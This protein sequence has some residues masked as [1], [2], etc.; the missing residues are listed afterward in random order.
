MKGTERHLGQPSSEQLRLRER[1]RRSLTGCQ[2]G[3]LPSL[4]KDIH[5]GAV[6]CNS[7]L[8]ELV[9][10][11]PVH[12]DDEGAE[13]RV[14]GHGGDAGA[15]EHL[16]R[17]LGGVVVG[18]VVAGDPQAS[19]GAE[20]T[21]ESASKALTVYVD[22]AAVAGLRLRSKPNTNSATLKILDS[23]T[24]LTVLEGTADMIGMDGKWLKVREPAGKEGHVAAWYVRK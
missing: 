14:A 21:D 15:L 13:H 19:Q 11:V 5:G 17:E 8:R 6:K 24:E 2:L 16:A 7:P 20:P 1:R 10:A 9:G 23:G 12:Q 18:R 22:D 4:K 3:A